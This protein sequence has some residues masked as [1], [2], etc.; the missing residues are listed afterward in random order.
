MQFIS[1]Y[2]SIKYFS[3]IF[4]LLLLTAC[5]E[6]RNNWDPQDY[7][8]KRG[9]TLYS[10][11]WR[12]EKD[13]RDI[14]SWNNIS[15]PY[16]IYPGQR[17]RMA[18]DSAEGTIDHGD[19][20]EIEAYQ[21]SPEVETVSI[22]EPEPIAST[23]LERPETAVVSKGD[24]LYSI[25]QQQ[26]L[27]PQQLARWN[28]LKSPYRL[29]PGQT[30]V[31]K[32]PLASLGS[33][34]TIVEPRPVVSVNIP[35]PVSKPRVKPLPQKVK[36]WQWPATGKLVKTFSTKDPSRKGIRIA[37]NR[38]QAV[39]AAA[40]GKV[41]YSGNGLIS[42]GNLVIIK[43]SGA[44]LSAY[45][46]NRKLL[47]KEGDEVRA[48]QAIA[49][50]GTTDSGRARLHFEIRKNGKPVNPLKYLPKRPG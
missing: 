34:S 45:A 39:M 30:L 18:A 21:P 22:S 19:K 40:R 1:I 10:I 26:G 41:V 2:K 48:G 24:T 46:Y 31:L 4:L 43:H 50:M 17:L 7:T 27:T 28:A 49:Q 14:A 36:T 15:T 20:P 44:Y 11:A 29:Y 16:A 5:G 25:A 47:V 35:A 12:Y 3:T 38:G 6:I 33:R 9:D 13:F 23:E 32:P 42:Y 8:V 37:G